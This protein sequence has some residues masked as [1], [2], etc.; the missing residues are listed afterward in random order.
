MTVSMHQLKKSIEKGKIH[1]AFLV[2]ALL[3]INYLGVYAVYLSESKF[4]TYF[5]VHGTAIILI[6]ISLRYL[7]DLGTYI[8]LS[9]AYLFIFPMLI[10]C[11]VASIMGFLQNSSV[12]DNFLNSFLPYASVVLILLPAQEKI[13]SRLLIMFRYQFIFAVTFAL[14]ILFTKTIHSGLMSRAE[15]YLSYEIIALQMLFLMP[16]FVGFSIGDRDWKYRLIT[17]LGYLMWVIFSLRGM[18]RSPSLQ[19][20]VFIPLAILL[21]NFRYR[22][23]VGQ[24]GFW[25]KMTLFICLFLVFAVVLQPDLVSKL[26]IINASAGTL[27]RFTGSSSL[28]GGTDLKS[29]LMNS[30]VT[31]EMENSRGAEI[32]DFMK[33]AGLID[34]VAGRGFGSTWYST[35]F[36]EE[37]SMIHVG[38]F[39]LILRGGIPLLITYFVFFL[40]ALL[41]SWK[42]SRTSPIA[43]GVF[44]FL[45]VR[46]VSFMSYG[47]QI[48][49]FT[50]YLFWLMIGLA[51]S[52]NSLKGKDSFFQKKTS[53]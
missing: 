13:R 27:Q 4:I 32:Q 31:Y 53:R 21:V 1:T 38:P 22:G 33:D 5:S 39:H 50:T 51:L 23:I 12:N 7:K 47:A 41:S 28:N 16:F 15:F 49:S 19:A 29:G 3:W 52:T 37:R 30:M 24:L 26:Q 40:T 35:L 9:Y 34:F 44:V 17:L 2:E 14:Y 6:L 8:K 46:L 25:F 43:M 10:I 45:C 11:F 48:S 36:G 20:V 42:N 18:M